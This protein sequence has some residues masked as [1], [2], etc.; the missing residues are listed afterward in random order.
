M[1]SRLLAVLQKTLV[2]VEVSSAGI[3][4]VLLVIVVNDDPVALEPY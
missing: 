2:R 3:T 1:N 4:P